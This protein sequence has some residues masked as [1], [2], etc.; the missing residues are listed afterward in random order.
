MTSVLLRRWTREE[1]EHMVAGGVFS[2]SDH[3]ELLDGEILAMTPQGSAHATAVGLVESALRPHFAAG[4]HLRTQRPFALDDKSE[5]EPDVVVVPGGLREYRNAHPTTA[6]FLVEVSDT[7]LL[8][9]RTHKARAYA[10]AGIPEYWVMNLPDGVL[11][12]YR[13]PN[14]APGTPLGWVYRT[15]RTLGPSDTITPLAAPNTQVPIRD[16]L[17]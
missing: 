5:P 15:T 4:H 6:V 2:P 1:Y 10:R 3:V 11:E 9:D 8:Y 7:T 12:V 17:P 16:L 14:P 13:D